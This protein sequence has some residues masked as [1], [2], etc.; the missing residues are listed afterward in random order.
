[1]YYK[2]LNFAP[3]KYRAKTEITKQYLILT[4]NY[5]DEDGNDDDGDENTLIRFLLNFRSPGFKKNLKSL[6]KKKEKFTKACY[7]NKICMMVF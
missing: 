6:E 5:V 1:M 2:S 3:L 4:V 7:L